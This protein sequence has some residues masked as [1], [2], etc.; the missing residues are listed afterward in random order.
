M[1]EDRRDPPTTLAIDTARRVGT[2]CLRT[3][4]GATELAG[5]DP[6]G[7]R[8][9][10][11]LV[12]EAVALCE[13]HGL[14]L[15]DVGLICVSVGPGSFTGLRV[16]VT[17]AKTLAFAAGCEVVGVPS[18][19]TVARALSGGDPPGTP[20]RIVSDALRGDLYQTDVTTA[21]GDRAP[22]FS[23]T[24]LV[25]EP[26]GDGAVVCFDPELIERLPDLPVA[27]APDG[28]G[29]AAEVLE[30]GLRLWR[31]GRTADPFA[32]V[33]LYVRRS[34]A[35]ETADSRDRAAGRMRPA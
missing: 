11:T 21:A 9:A 13:R 35:E 16:G 15:A 3:A 6:K 31:A 12:P 30:A 33:P 10:R 8:N 2:L 26:E 14:K 4:D 18:H 7:R 17:F 5:L 1:S 19:L 25:A 24:R 27:P 34:S 20:L 22:E 23:P 32:L 28:R 29:T